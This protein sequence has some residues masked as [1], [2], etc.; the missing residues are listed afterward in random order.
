MNKLSAIPKRLYYFFLLLLLYIAAVVFILY[1]IQLRINH[2][3]KAEKQ[4]FLIKEKI[5]ILN[6]SHHRL[7]TTILYGKDV[8][9][10]TFDNTDK[11][12]D[13]IFMELD[14]SITRL[15]NIK[16]LVKKLEVSDQI[17]LFNHVISD[18][19]AANS[20]LIYSLK[21]RGSVY[22]GVISKWMKQTI[23]IEN[24]LRN[25]SE[26]LLIGIETIKALQYEYL[27]TNNNS[28]TD[29]LN[30]LTLSIQSQLPFGEMEISGRFDTLMQLTA[31]IKALND[32]IGFSTI[33]GELHAYNEAYKQVNGTF[34]DLRNRIQKRVHGTES[35][36]YI[37]GFAIILFLFLGLLLS[38]FILFRK[39]LM[40]PMSIIRQC[41]SE[42]AAG[43]LPEGSLKIDPSDDPGGLSVEL[44]KLAEGLKAKTHFAQDLNQGQLDTEIELL[45]ERD[46]LGIEMKKFQ[47]NLI[48]SSE[49]QARYNEENVRRRYINEGLAK[50]GNI[51]RINSN[52]LTNLGDSFIRELV[53]YL[54]AIQGGF[55]MLDETDKQKPV[56]R[57]S[58]AFA[59]DRK[60]YIEKTIL[61]GEGLVG[62]CAIEKKTV[63]LTEIPG[64][65]IL[66]T[67]GLGDAPPDNLLLVP[68]LHESTLVGVLEIA[69]LNKFNE[70]EITFT[71]E[72]AGNL[73]STIITTRVNQ[74]T[75]DLL[76]KSQQQAI[77][78]AE[79]EEEMRQNMEELKATQEESLRR[80]EEF[81]GIVNSLNMSVFLIE[82][83]LDG[84]IT[85]INDK[86]L[87][88]LN[89]KD[90]ELLGKS[91]L[92]IFGINS[93]V[94]SKFWSR[95]SNL[96]NTTIIEKL[97]LGKKV[98]YFK[99]HFA[100]VTNKD[101]LPVKVLNIITE[102]PEKLTI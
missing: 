83:D 30:A 12:M 73:G 48:T 72:V 96:S 45:S 76:A 13:N 46:E 91:H 94:D 23:D 43:M 10:E 25:V 63:H 47:N 68:V 27:L 82:Y 87:V 101:G 65:Y 32:R 34:E 78:M 24:S 60:K 67:S 64:G 26:D 90:K 80:E 7:L 59:Y 99:E 66:I 21:E 6:A 11:K 52:N 29:E 71:E 57:L 56:L 37:S 84:T 100:V 92:Y 70:H 22:S 8:G 16:V 41:V 53:K 93:V 33:Q 15:G 35:C 98:Y 14:E 2:T 102:I 86:F 19:S 50:F 95:L 54:N 88:F 81:R 77:E 28:I 20:I 55:F 44:N 51:L 4:L 79:Q 39:G 5:E 18:Y 1:F 38:A 85:S 97:I 62:T 3:A 42:L 40:N 17:E 58:A 75:S 61:M 89:K 9:K 31:E 69:S 74:R 49:E 36:S